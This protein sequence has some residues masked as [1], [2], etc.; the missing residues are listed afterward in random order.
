M[1]LSGEVLDAGFECFSLVRLAAHSSCFLL[2][3]KDVF[4]A[5]A[6]LPVM[7]D[8]YPSGTV[9]QK[10]FFY[11]LLSAMVFYVNNRKVTNTDG[12]GG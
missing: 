12:G 8:S 5:L 9:S 2:L 6:E 3:V 10:K 11:K 4:S 1:A 7:A